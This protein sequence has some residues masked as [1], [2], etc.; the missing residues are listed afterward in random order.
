MKEYEKYA[1]KYREIIDLPHPTSLTHPRMSI[2]DRAAQFAPFSA[3]TGYDDAIDET[4]RLTDKMV[5]L[6]DEM[7]VVLDRK[8]AFLSKIMSQTPEISVTYFL[9]D[10]KKEGGVYKTMKG[11][12]KRIDDYEKQLIFLDGTKISLDRI[13]DIESDLFHVF[14]QTNE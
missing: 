2:L 14:T 4:A 13:Y 6:S 7:K 1:E 11:C 10:A 3:L 8:Q 5:E 9:D 12:L